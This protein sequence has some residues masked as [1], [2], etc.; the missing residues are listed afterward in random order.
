MELF[1]NVANVY[2][3][4]L[5]QMLIF[6]QISELPIKR[7]WF[8]I[9]PAA[10][11]G[12]FSVV[13]PIAYF[14]S[15]IMYIAYCFY[16]NKGQ[17][18]MMNLFYGLYPVVVESLFGRML[19]YN[20]FPMLGI[21]VFNETTISGYDILIELLIFPVYLLIIH[22]LKIDF[23][24]LKEG[25]KRQYFNTI[26]LIIN[27]SMILYIILVSLFVVLRNQLS[28][29]DMWRGQLNNLY[30]ILFFIM[31]LYVN[32]TSKE[33]LEQEIVAQKDRQLRELSNYSSLCSYM[34]MLLRKK[35]SNKKL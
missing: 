28:D 23:K 10:F 15:F 14:A 1:L 9:I 8:L 3:K 18:R 11:V 12:L 17:S 26:L 30:I 5:A 19:G 2:L 27:L 24:D 34:S 33:K 4:I 20:V 21:T 31:L 7:K 6:K 22:S 35:N 16:I 25:F 32:A 13:P 29:A